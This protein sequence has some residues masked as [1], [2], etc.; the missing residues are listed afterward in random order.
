MTL[1]DT[2]KTL[3]AAE[4]FFGLLDVDFDPAVMNRARLHILKRMGQ[5]IANGDLDGMSD[6]E[7]FAAAR[8]LLNRAYGE[9]VGAQAID[10]RLFKVLSDRDPHRPAT[11]GPFVPLSDLQMFSPEA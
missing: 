2:M 3:H 4:D 11:R 9:F 10:K 5:L 7:A 8:G 6:A 1:L